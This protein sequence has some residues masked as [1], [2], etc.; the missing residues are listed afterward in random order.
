MYVRTYLYRA[1]T[2]EVALD[3]LYILYVCMYVRTYV[4]TYLYRARTCEVA[5]DKLNICMYVRTCLYRARTCE[6]ALDI[7]V[8]HHSWILP[9]MWV[10]SDVRQRWT[11]QQ[12]QASE[13]GSEGSSRVG[14]CHR[15][16]VTCCKEDGTNVGKSAVSDAARPSDPLSIV[17]TIYNYSFKFGSRKTKFSTRNPCPVFR[18][19]NLDL[20][21]HSWGTWS[22]FAS[23]VS[24]LY[25]VNTA[26][27]WSYP[28]NFVTHLCINLNLIILFWGVI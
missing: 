25:I 10:F 18:F 5:L 1:R 4:R 22:Y 14:E 24:R 28:R 27:H 8:W 9:C 7:T 12:R 26:S 21:C 16:G 3:K 2:C 23:L 11:S 17:W 15:F 20:C 13:R 6:V 19:E